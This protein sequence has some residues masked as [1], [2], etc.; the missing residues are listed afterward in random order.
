MNSQK[1]KLLRNTCEGHILN[2]DNHIYIRY[3]LSTN[4]EKDGLDRIESDD[5]LFM[6][7]SFVYNYYIYLSYVEL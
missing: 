7:L 1:I 4:I 2:L 5:V 6:D 3:A